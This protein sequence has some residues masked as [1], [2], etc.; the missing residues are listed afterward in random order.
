M[1]SRE[2]TESHFS[3]PG[4]VFSSIFCPPC[5]VLEAVRPRVWEAAI[6]PGRHDEHTRNRES[7]QQSTTIKCQDSWSV[8]VLEVKCCLQPK[9]QLLLSAVRSE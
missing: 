2:I 1:G 7:L 4:Q 6:Y 5:I 3:S 9:L 8:L